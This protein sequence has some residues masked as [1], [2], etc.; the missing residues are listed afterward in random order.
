MGAILRLVGSFIAKGSGVEP[1]NFSAFRRASDFLAL[2]HWADGTPAAGRV[3]PPYR[4]TPY[5]DPPVHCAAA[6]CASG[7]FVPH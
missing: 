5:Q 6:A 3:W 2:S 1:S 4:S 7:L